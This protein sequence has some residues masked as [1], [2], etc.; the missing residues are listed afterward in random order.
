MILSA[1]GK[2]PAGFGGGTD[3]STPE[4]HEAVFNAIREQ[5]EADL[6]S[7]EWSVEGFRPPS[8]SKIRAALEQVKFSL[9]DVRTS[10]EDPDSTMKFC[11]GDVKATFPTEMIE[12]ANKSLSLNNQTSI[13]TAVENSDA[14]R[15]ANSISIAIDYNIQPTDDGKKIF[16]EI[17]DHERVTN[18]VNLIVWGHLYNRQ[19][20]QSA[21]ETQQAEAAAQAEQ[22]SALAASRSASLEEAKATHALSDQALTAIWTA[23]PQEQRNQLLP[24]QRAWIKKKTADCRITAASASIEPTEKETARLHCEARQNQERSDMLRNAA[25]QARYNDETY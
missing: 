14:K 1:C 21:I 8:K 10:K 12:Q 25:N 7:S 15:M 9:I 17:E 18:L 22:E 13:S 19:I 4:G 5:V 23:I 11:V 24:L 16:A 20:T 3:C 2:L 6:S